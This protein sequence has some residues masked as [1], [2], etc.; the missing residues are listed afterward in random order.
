MDFIKNYISEIIEKRKLWMQE[1]ETEY[2]IHCPICSDG[3]PNHFYLSKETG[4]FI[5]Q[6]CNVKG[7]FNDFRAFWGD[8][9]IPLPE[10]MKVEN[11]GNKKK[12]KKKSNK[13]YKKID[14]ERVL[15]YM[16]NL[17]GSELKLL[18]YLKKERGLTEDTIKHFKLGVDENKNIIIPLFDKDGEVVNLRKRKNPFSDNKDMA[19]YTMEKGC[20]SILFNEVCITK[21]LKELTY[22]EGEFDTMLLWQK[23]VK[24]IV[25]GSQGVKYFPSDWLE[26]VKH[27]KKHTIIFD[28]DTAG[29]E[30]AENLAQKLGGYKTK[31]V[32]LPL[33]ENEKKVDIT[34][35][36]IKHKNSDEDFKSLINE[37]KIYAQ[38]EINSIKHISEFNEALR[39][40][41]LAGDYNGTPTG[42]NDLDKIIGGYR[43]GRLI[44]LSGDTSIGKCVAFDSEIANP[45]NGSIITM[46][47]FV[48]KKRQKILSYEYDRIF[49]RKVLNWVDSGTKTVY[50]V[51]TEWGTRCKV[52]AEHPFLT[53]DFS[54]KQL[55]NLKV[56][57]EIAI[58]RYI[59]IQG[60][61]R[62]TKPAHEIKL[63]AYLLADG[64]TP[65]NG[66]ITFSKTD[67]SILDDIEKCLENI[68]CVLNKCGDCTYRIINKN[69]RNTDKYNRDKSYSKSKFGEEF[70]IKAHIGS[71]CG[72]NNIKKLLDSYNYK[73]CTSYTK[74][75]PSSI[76]SLN[77]EKQ[78][79]FLSAIMSCDGSCFIMNKTTICLSYS[80]T[81]YRLAKQI[82]HL[83]LR[84]HIDMRIRTKKTNFDTIAYELTTNTISDVKTYYEK[85]GFI[86]K[87]K[88][89]ILENIKYKEG[90]SNKFSNSALRFTKINKITNK[91]KQQVYDI[92]VEGSH[93]FIV[94]D[95]LVHNTAY[96]CNLSIKLAEK[97]I[98]SIFISMEMSP[99]DITKRFL[100]I[101]KK[102]NGKLLEDK[103]LTEESDVMKQVDEGLLEFK[104]GGKSGEGLP[105]YLYK[106]SGEISLD[107]VKQGIRIAKEM[108]GTEVV[109]LDHLGFFVRGQGSN[110]ERA[111]AQ[112]IRELKGLAMELDMCIVLLA[113]ISRYG[114][115]QK[116]TGMYV[117]RIS[118]LKG[119]SAIEQDA[120]QVIFVARDNEAK[121][122]ENK[123]QMIVK[124]AKNRDGAT[125]YVSCDF[126]LEIGNIEETE[127]DYYPTQKTKGQKPYNA[128]WK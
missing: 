80:T 102:I 20:R 50:E 124:V 63:I 7:G 58:P 100:Q 68:D 39:E 119:S 5:C 103:N 77:K 51:E 74:E 96:S 40:K 78:A 28:N 116:R 41:L 49:K 111:I 82:K 60:D 34:D 33:M 104:Q 86:S 36:F 113:H 123:K 57:D 101:S 16:G 91:G 10:G 71:K 56:G 31:I 125:G 37:S 115:Q 25:S 95:M 122:I 52:T 98:P 19:R 106:E 38:E 72:R 18:E 85:I 30:G 35:Y 64:Y 11:T 99:I 17:F 61:G 128:N 13:I 26:Q 90:R 65:Q 44:V 14:K 89:S 8:S 6:K 107:T 117:P 127:Q 76:F 62:H 12:I 21:D 2:N 73:Y 46:E 24:N 67:T 42:F 94:D 43:K 4:Q 83:F 59:H 47:E 53:N 45:V 88:Q 23:G 112:T 69:G 81:S 48:K 84:F 27:I 120:D 70:E 126:E 66:S 32:Q 121:D 29:R 22:C 9:A 75:I 97:E 1:N 108:Y 92:E 55:Q 105:I 15:K 109:F 79:V 3:K 87:K 114:K 93:N 118:D 54:W 110:E